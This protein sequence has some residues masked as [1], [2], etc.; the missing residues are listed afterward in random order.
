[1]VGHHMHFVGVEAKLTLQRSQAHGSDTTCLLQVSPWNFD[2]QL[3]YTYEDPTQTYVPLLAGDVLALSCTY[4]NTW[5]NS[6]WAQALA[7][8][9]VSELPDVGL[10]DGSLAEMCAA[11]VGVVMDP[12]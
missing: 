7:L 2:W 11:L 3:F 5:T 10:S 4:D 12:Q 9:G 1:M 8:E 6:K